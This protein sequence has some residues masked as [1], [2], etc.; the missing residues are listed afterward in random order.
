MAQMEQPVLS[1]SNHVDDA[2]STID[3][4]VPLKIL[5]YQTVT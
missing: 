2:P 5:Y 4:P 3:G 1:A